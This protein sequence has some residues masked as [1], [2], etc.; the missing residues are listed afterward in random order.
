MSFLA[1]AYLFAGRC[2]ERIACCVRM[3]QFRLSGLELRLLEVGSGTRF[4]VP[5][6]SGGRG[7][8]R[9]G[10]N[11]SFGWRLAPRMGN[12][13]IVLQPRSEDAE[14]VVGNG[15]A[16]SNNISIVAMGKIT[17][18]DGCLIGDQ[19][20]ILDCDFHEMDPRKRR[21]G[22]GPVRP[23]TIGDNVWLGSRVMVLKGVSIGDNS[24]VAAMSVVT[25]S[26]PANTLV[27]GNPAKII[28]PIHAG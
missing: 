25:K 13:E 3:S 22:V 2:C 24:V 1:R 27:A 14:I 8:L 4:Y 11:N 7:A 5:A 21:S 20:A 23:V 15:N 28:R 16:F 6:R 26:V 19:V 9:I 17:I 18:G 10:N 12:G